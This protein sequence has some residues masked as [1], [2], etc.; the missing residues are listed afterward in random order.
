MSK[1]FRL[2]SYMY[3]DLT[4]DGNRKMSTGMYVK[5]KFLEKR[6]RLLVCIIITRY[7]L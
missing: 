5:I 3:I 1:K 7:K 2:L 4:K 6:V